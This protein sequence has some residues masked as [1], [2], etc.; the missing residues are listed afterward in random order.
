MARSLIV[1]K[2]VVDGVDTIQSYGTI[3]DLKLVVYGTACSV[4]VG[5]LVWISKEIWEAW[6]K[7]NDK[8]SDKL[9]LLVTAVNRIELK[10]Q[11]M[12]DAIVPHHKIIEIVR[13]EIEYINRSL[14]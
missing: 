1:A 8:S 14:P 3:Q 13:D 7:K 10:M 5:I 11:S 6:K 2:G 12:E 9:D 4:L